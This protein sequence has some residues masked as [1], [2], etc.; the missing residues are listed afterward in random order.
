MDA[1]EHDLMLSG[2][3]TN[4]VTNKIGYLVTQTRIEYYK[5]SAVVKAT[6]VRADLLVPF[7]VYTDSDTVLIPEMTDKQGQTFLE[8][9]LKAL[10]MIQPM[11]ALDNN[12]DLK[13]QA[14][15]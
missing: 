12:Q 13:Q 10:S 8:R 11:D 14:N 4:T 5:M 3:Y 15:G 6:G 9:V 1:R 2:T 7:S